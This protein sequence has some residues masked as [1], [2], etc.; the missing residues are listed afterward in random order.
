M[1]TDNIL[2]L[3]RTKKNWEKT[4]ENLGGVFMGFL[5][6]WVLGVRRD[7]VLLR[8]EVRPIEWKVAF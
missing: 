2:T 4:Y 3:K 6:G 5:D 1:G 8:S 7:F